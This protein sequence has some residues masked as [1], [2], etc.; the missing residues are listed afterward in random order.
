M[1]WQP[2][3]VTPPSNTSPA[4]SGTV[5]VDISLN[6]ETVTATLDRTVAPCTVN[7]FVSLASQGFYDDTDCYRLTKSAEL[8]ILQCGDPTN[9]GNGGPG[10]TFADENT[11]NTK[12]PVGSLAMANAGSSSTTGAGTN[13]SQ[14]FIVYDT[15]VPTGSYTVF[16]KVSDSGMKV[17]QAIAAKG[18]E[19]G[20][21]SGKPVSQASI[22]KI[23]VP[24]D[25]VAATGNWPTTTASAP[26]ASVPEESCR[27]R[28]DR[29][30]TRGGSGTVESTGTATPS[31]S[32]APTQTPV[33]QTTTN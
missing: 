16:G 31:E 3:A 7:S 5:D 21:Q 9:Q 1:A 18:V 14:F 24:T 23:T 2:S 19:K 30:R 11:E 26:E 32:A 12:Y 28:P 27:D 33:S 22:E 20:Q 29:E 15:T 4:N 8:N 13:G 25:A 6:G 10:Y 17:V